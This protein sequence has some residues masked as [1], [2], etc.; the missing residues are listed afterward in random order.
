MSGQ[1]KLYATAVKDVK[2]H[3]II[4]KMINTDTQAKTVNINPGTLKIGKKVT[5]IL[6]SAPQLSS[7]NN[8]D[9][10]PV[11]PKEENS[12]A[13]KGKISTEIPANSLVVLKVKTI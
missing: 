5:Q 8:F 7:E 11:K 2:T 10:E 6:L 1:E 9:A 12:E 4:I 13:K 3:E